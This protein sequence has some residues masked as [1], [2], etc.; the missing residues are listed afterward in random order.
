MGSF[1]SKEDDVAKISTSIF[2]SNFSDSV[3]AKDLFHSCKQYGHV[4]DSFIPMKRLKDG[5]R[6]GFVRFI[7]VFNVE[8]LVNNLCTIW[9]NRCKLHANIARFNRDQKNGNKYKTANQKKHEGRKNTFYDPSKEAG[10]FDSRNSFVNVL[11]GT[12]MV[13]ETDSSPVIVL[14][15]DCLNS[16]DLSNS[17]IGRVKDVGSLSNLKKVLCNEG[18]DN[19]FVRYMGELWVLL[20][21][22]NTKAKELFRD[23][24]GVGSWFSVLR[25]ASHDFTPEGR[26]AWVDVEGIPFKFWSGKTFKKIATKWGELLDVDDHDEMSFHSKRIC[27]HTKICS[28]ICEN[29]KIVFKGKVHWIRAKEATGWIP[30]FSEDEEDDDHSEQEFISSEQSDLGLHIDGEDN[31]AS[32]VP[33]T[34][35]EN[36][37]GMKERQSEDPFGLY[38]ILNKNKVKSDVIREVND[39]NPSLKYPP[40]FTPS[41]EKN[42][43]KSKD[44]QVQN[45]SDNQLNGDNESVHQVEREDNRNSDGAKTNSTG[46]RKFKMSEI[47][48]TGGSILSVMEEIVKVGIT[49][50][51]NMDGC[52]AQKAKKDWV[53]EL[54]NKNKVSF[55]GL[56]ETKMESID[57]LSVRLCWGNVNFDYVHS[58]FIGNSGGILCIWDPNS[59]RKDNVTV[60]DYFVI[61]RGVW[62]KSGIDILIIVVYT[63]HD[64]KDKRL[65]WDYLSHVSNQWAGEVVMMGDFNEVR[66][67]SDRFRSNFNA[68]GADIFNNFFINAGLEEVPLGGSAYTWCHKSASK[69]SKLDRFLVSENLLNTCPNISAITLDRFL[70]DHRPILLNSWKDA[71]GDDSNA[72]RNLC[73]KLKF[74]KVKI[75]AWYADYRNNSKGSVTNFKEELRILDELIDKGNGSDEIVNNRL[76]ILGKLQ[77]VNK[78]QASEVA[79]KAKIKWY[80]EGDENTK[81]FHGML[82]KKRM[83][84]NFRGINDRWKRTLINPTG[85]VKQEFFQHFR[86]RMRSKG[87]VLDDGIDHITGSPEGFTFGFYRHFWSTIENDNPDANMVKDFRPISLIGSIYK[88]IAKILTNRL[89]GVLGDIV[90][91]VQ[92]AFISERQILD[93]PFILNEIMQWCRRRKKQSLIFKVDFEKAYDSVRWDFLD[94][95]LV[96]FGFGIK[97]RGWIQ[98]CLNSSKGSILVNGSPTEEF[99]FYKGLKQGDPL[100]PFLFILVMESLHISFQRVVD[101]GMFTGIKLSSS[102]NISHLFYADDAIFLG[103]WND[104]NIDTLVHVMECFYRV[105]GLRINL[106]KSKIMGIHVDADRI[107]SAASKLGCLVL[108]TPFLYLGTK[109]GENMS[110][111]H[112]WKEVIVKIKSRLSNWKLKTLSIGGRFTLLKSVL[113]S[114]PIFHMSIYKVPSS[115]LHLLESIRSHFFHGHDPRSK[116][117]S[118]VNWN[119]VLTAKERGGLGVSSLYALN[120]GLMCKWVWRFFAHKS[121]LWSRVIKAIHGPEGG[122]ITDVRRGF[123]STWTSIVQEVKKL[124]NQGV[125]IFDYIRIKIGN[126]DNTS[127]WKDKWHN[128]GVLK[129]VFPRLYALE[130]HQNVTIHT[131]LIDYSLVNSFRRNPRSGV[132]EFQLDNLSRLVSTITLSSAVDRYVWSLENSGEFSVKSIRQ[133]IDANCF[134]VIHS[135]TRWVKSVPLKVN[136]MAWKIKMD[137]LP[138][139]MNISRRGIEIDSI[140]CP[141]C[142]SGAESSCHIFF[143]CNLVRQL[144]RKISSWWNVDYVDVSSYEEWYT[145]LVSL[146]LQANLKAVFE[147][148]F[149]CLWWSVWMFRNKILFEKDTPS[150]ARIFDNIVSNSYYWSTQLDIHTISLAM[151]TPGPP[152][153]VARRAM[154]ELADFS[155][156]TEIPKRMKF[157]KLQQISEAWRFIN[158]MSNQAQNSRTCI[159]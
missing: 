44:D 88:I 118:W 54:C 70:S 28:N 93:G 32:E 71:P 109:V 102:L 87:T 60:S 40:G 80:V 76:E 144:A 104:S 116:K 117:A 157:F 11:K 62:I 158:L 141:I 5:K 97:W 105:S 74:L 68:H 73:G 81:F 130:R 156:E 129:D 145:W 19:I 79:Q 151:K 137:G 14:E 25:Q 16:K 43:S 135:A 2:V 127:F 45:I 108:N 6:F 52:L 30:E 29:F 3:S 66:Y 131:K 75:R 38:S 147:G 148:I 41:V 72:M 96:K 140:V 58:D 103:Q 152:N 106:C 20:E 63:P 48:R 65:L 111:V 21:F 154:D 55:V 84:L 18:F 10:T 17:L 59:F 82:N 61:V 35:F 124:Q 132:E 149:Y 56:Q 53:K 51:Y 122:L 98:N 22:D 125:N 24:V 83:Q 49:M 47:P 150:Q 100:S 146:R 77:Q 57:L 85:F 120:R 101:V 91:E 27:I 114:T 159:A 94:D 107:K 90:N 42:G 92:S 34:I 113:G 153:P 50:G 89:V 13:K 26:I 15:E 86:N 110:R 155:G 4:V 9:L 121:L 112:A 12:N 133:V 136:I 31:G 128:E 37:D 46:S 115:V 143:Q 36:S 8:R 126:G 139:R 123:R 138:T 1:R 134:P 119:K 39:E 99:Q 64:V 95:I 33:E 78:A 69:M 67:K 23:N 7:N 142:N